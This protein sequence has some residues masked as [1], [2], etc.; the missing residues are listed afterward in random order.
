M[1]CGAGRGQDAAGRTRLV[2]SGSVNKD[3][4]ASVMSIVVSTTIP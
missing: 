4:F 2:G 3:S 1:V